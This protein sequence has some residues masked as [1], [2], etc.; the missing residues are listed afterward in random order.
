[1]MEIS[2]DN[3][4]SIL[5]ILVEFRKLYRKS[6]GASMNISAYLGIHGYI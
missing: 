2:K 4:P 5:Q 6:A 3:L 1:M